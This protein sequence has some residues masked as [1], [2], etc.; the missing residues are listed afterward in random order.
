MKAYQRF[1][2]FM[3]QEHNLVLT[4]GEMDDIIHEA[5]LFEK[6][7]DEEIQRVNNLN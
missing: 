6:N 3:N 2:D 1:F 5:Q 7:Y 4:H